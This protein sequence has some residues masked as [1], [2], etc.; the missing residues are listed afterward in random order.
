MGSY[1]MKLF[2]NECLHMYA[3]LSNMINIAFKDNKNLHHCKY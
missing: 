2:L 1:F 3:I